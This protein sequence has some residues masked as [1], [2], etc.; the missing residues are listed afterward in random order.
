VND[1]LYILGIDPG[2]VKCGLAVLHKNSMQVMLR[3][4]APRAQVLFVAQRICRTFRIDS[5]ALGSGT[6]ATSAGQEMANIGPA[7]LLVNEYGSTLAARARYFEAKPPRGW[8]RFIPRG[9]LVPN[10]PIDDWAAVII[11]E[12][13]LAEHR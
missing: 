4:I 2:R 11:A 1:D 13:F 8:K 6:E 12:R 9:L 7:V 5:I 3:E 10:E